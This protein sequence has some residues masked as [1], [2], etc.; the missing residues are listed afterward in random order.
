MSPEVK[1]TGKYEVRF[2]NGDSEIVD[3]YNYTWDDGTDHSVWF[4]DTDGDIIFE[5]SISNVRWVK[6][7]S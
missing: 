6:R 2:L 4:E 7:L 1:Q 3:A 5:A